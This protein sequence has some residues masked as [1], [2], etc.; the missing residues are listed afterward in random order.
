MNTNKFNYKTKKKEGIQKKGKNLS[1]NEDIITKNFKYAL[2][3]KGNQH[4]NRWKRSKGCCQKR[5]IT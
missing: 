1:K 3:Y 2:Y 4:K 5:K